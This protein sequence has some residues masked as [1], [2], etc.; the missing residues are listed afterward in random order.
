MDSTLSHLKNSYMI[1]PLAV[2]IV[3]SLMKFDETLTGADKPTSDY[4]KAVLVTSLLSFFFLY[5]HAIDE[6]TFEVG[7][8]GIPSF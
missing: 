6:S 2:L 8:V 7:K 1:I 3:A 5:V 4:V